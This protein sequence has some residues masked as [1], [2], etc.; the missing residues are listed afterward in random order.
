MNKTQD[1][2]I[3]EQKKN[4]Q[5]QKKYDIRGYPTVVVLDPTGQ[6]IAITGYRAGGGSSYSDH[7]KQIVN[8][9]RGLQSKGVENSTPMLRELNLNISTKKQRIPSAR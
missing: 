3:V 5:L 6:Q 9:Y 1:P 4:K 2:A 8:D 7:L